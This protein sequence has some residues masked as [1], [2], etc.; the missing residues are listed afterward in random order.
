MKARQPASD[1][2][3]RPLSATG[4]PVASLTMGKRMNYSRRHPSPRYV[5][6]LEQ[7]RSLHRSGSTQRNLG[8]QET[9]SGISLFAHLQRIKRL[10]E[11]TGAQQ[12]M[13]Y[14]AGKGLAYAM[15]PL[16]IP[17]VGRVDTLIDFWNVDYVHCYDPCHEPHSRLPAE[18]FD[19]VI[20]TDVMEHCPEEDLPWIVDEM[21]SYARKFVFANIASYPAMMILPNGENAHITLR[22]FDWWRT[23][24][25]GSGA[26][27]P[28]I[29]WHIVVQ[30]LEPSAAG[31]VVVEEEASGAAPCV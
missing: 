24:F 2:P 5:A 14:G 19:G 4:A 1:R 29:H 7:Y 20:S 27:H 21:F 13:D 17:G 15:S 12:I 6:M 10:A 31:R 22:P 9:Y 28:H 30:R 11:L 23:L 26:S 18:Q 16:D 25:A 8:S 3:A